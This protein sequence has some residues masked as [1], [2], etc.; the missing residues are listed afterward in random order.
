MPAPCSTTLLKLA[1]LA[2]PMD[3]AARYPSPLCETGVRH[4]DLAADASEKHPVVCIHQGLSTSFFFDA[5]LARVELEGRE[6]FRRVLEGDDGLTVVPSEEMHDA[7]P[8]HLTIHFRDGAAPTSANFLFVVHP[9]L[10]ARQVDVIRLT[11]PV[12]FY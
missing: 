9:A 11:R 2:L 7:E 10:A 1:L 6:R 12:A 8:V 5:K 3:A 4:I